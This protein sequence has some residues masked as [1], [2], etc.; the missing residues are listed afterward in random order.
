MRFQNL[1]DAPVTSQ[2]GQ[3]RLGRVDG[4]SKADAGALLGAVGGDHGVDADDFA[5]GAEQRAAGVD[6]RVGLDGVLDGRAISIANGTDGADD[7]P[8]HGAGKAEGIADGVDF[9]AH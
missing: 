2:I 7:A 6:G 4:D 9:L 8:R 3:H 1:F 5:A